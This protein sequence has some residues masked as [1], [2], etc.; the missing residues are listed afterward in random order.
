MIALIKALL[1]KWKTYQRH[2][3]S[4]AHSYTRVEKPNERESCHP[5]VSCKDRLRQQVS[6][7]Y[8][9]QIRNPPERPSK[10]ALDELDID[11]LSDITQPD[12]EAD[13]HNSAGDR[14]RMQTASLLEERGLGRL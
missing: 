14:W 2:P 7:L 13:M 6:E 10:I 9:Q 5:Q 4:W 11:E 12:S 8:L 1:V 3:A